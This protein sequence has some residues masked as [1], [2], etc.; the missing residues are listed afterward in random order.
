MSIKPKDLEKNVSL[1]VEFDGSFLSDN[2]QSWLYDGCLDPWTL[3]LKLKTKAD[4]FNGMIA[5]ASHAGCSQDLISVLKYAKELGA[6]WVFFTKEKL[7]KEAS[8]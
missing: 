8:K 7:Y 1:S 6:M 3:V 5:S 4:G 2:D